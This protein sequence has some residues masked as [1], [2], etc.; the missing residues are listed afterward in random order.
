MLA[1]PSS[2]PFRPYNAPNPSGGLMKPTIAARAADLI[3]QCRVASLAT[4]HDYAP[5]V[6][7]TPFAMLQ[8]PF[9]FVVLV[10]RLSAHTADMLADPRVALL[11]VE[12][13]RQGEPVHALARLSVQGD[14]RPLAPDDVNYV[15]GRAA[16]SSRFPDMTALFELAD[17]T[18]FAIRPTTARMVAGFADAHSLTPTALAEAVAPSAGGT[19]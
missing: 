10:S 4:V 1:V 7:M 13:E 5:R 15:A 19:Q 17:F 8:E 18:L 11:V 12:P 14:A 16:Y 3:R 6:S 2:A 9:A